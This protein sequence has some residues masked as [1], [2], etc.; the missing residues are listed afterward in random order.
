MVTREVTEWSVTR[1]DLRVSDLKGW[2]KSR[3]LFKNRFIF[4]LIN[5]YNPFHFCAVPLI[6]NCIKGIHSR[7]QHFYINIFMTATR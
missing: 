4:D 5:F 1:L 6:E 7:L 3:F 2:K